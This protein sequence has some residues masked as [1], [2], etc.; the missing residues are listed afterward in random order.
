MDCLAMGRPSKQDLKSRAERERKKH[1]RAAY[2]ARQT[3]K[4]LKVWR[5]WATA[6][7]IKIY[8]SVKKQMPKLL[9]LA[10][11][12]SETPDQEESTD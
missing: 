4:G 6:E 8:Q 3:E 9:E 11:Q 2:V 7:E 5:T 12:E 1:N 10:R